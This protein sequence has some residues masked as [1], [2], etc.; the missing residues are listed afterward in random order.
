MPFIHVEVVR[1][2][3]FLQVVFHTSDTVA[4]CGGGDGVW[5]G[6]N[7]M[8]AARFAEAIHSILLLMTA[9]RQL[10]VPVSYSTSTCPRQEAA[11]NT[12][13]NIFCIRVQIFKTFFTISYYSLF[14]GASRLGQVLTAML[15]QYLY[16]N[17]LQVT[18]SSSTFSFSFLPPQS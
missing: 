8:P 3:L 10:P 7:K 15:Y 12:G 6:E 14:S 16:H 18:P 1:S 2:L 9:I 5:G 13:G 11:K 4:V 17:T